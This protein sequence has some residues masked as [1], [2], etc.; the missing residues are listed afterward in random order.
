MRYLK[1]V[2]CIVKGRLKNFFKEYGW[3]IGLFINMFIYIYLYVYLVGGNFGLNRIILLV[4][5][6]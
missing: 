5:I 2:L 4:R 1:V 6:E 3:F